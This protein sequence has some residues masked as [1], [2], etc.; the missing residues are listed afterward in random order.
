MDR[1]YIIMPA[2]NEEETIQEVVRGWHQVVRDVGEGSRLV[3][4][5]DGSRDRTPQIL[6]ALKGQL[7]Q[8]V[9]LTKENGGHGPAIRFGYQYALDQGADYVFQTDSDGQTVPGEFYPMWAARRDYDYQ[10]GWRKK[11]QDGWSRAVVTRVLRLVVLATLWVWV[12][13]ANAPFRLMSGPTLR[14]HLDYV[15]ENCPLT[16]VALAAFYGKSGQRGRFLPI[17]FLP[18]QGGTNSIGLGRVWKIGWRALW[19]LGR[20][21]R[22]FERAGGGKER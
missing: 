2:Y 17:T 19:D 6:Q 18:R 4:V 20:L 7:P 16:N 5:D 8:L 10:I 15:P 1:L 21:N 3:V 13:D 14:R 22:S 9:C 11:R 12:P